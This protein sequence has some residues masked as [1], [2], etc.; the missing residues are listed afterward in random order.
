M[1]QVWR[2]DPSKSLSPFSIGLRIRGREEPSPR[3]QAF[4]ATPEVL[5]PGKVAE[6]RDKQLL[7]WQGRSLVPMPVFFLSSRM[8][9]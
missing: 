1:A 6:D 2:R 3:A 7:P 5:P 9:Y 8:T 4:D